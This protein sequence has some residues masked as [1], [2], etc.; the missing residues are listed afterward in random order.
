MRVIIKYAG[1][2]GP[3]KSTQRGS[4]AIEDRGKER[5]EG[6]EESPTNLQRPQERLSQQGNC[7]HVQRVCSQF[8]HEGADPTV[9]RKDK[10]D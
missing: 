9:H 1:S 8:S 10:K 2:M 7:V 3:D 4:V 6:Q 5:R